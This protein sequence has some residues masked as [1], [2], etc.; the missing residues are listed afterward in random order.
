MRPKYLAFYQRQFPIIFPLKMFICRSFTF[1]L[2]F[3]VN[4][5]IYKF[6]EEWCK[7]ELFLTY[8]LHISRHPAIITINIFIATRTPHAHTQTHTNIIG[9]TGN[10]YESFNCCVNVYVRCHLKPW[11]QWNRKNKQTK[12]TN[13]GT[14]LFH[15]SELGRWQSSSSYILTSN[16]KWYACTRLPPSRFPVL[17]GV[18]SIYDQ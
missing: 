15:V 3:L 8:L 11:K 18:N 14:F 9:I 4:A 17:N 5:Y 12:L 10:L 7:F 16:G 2:L 1:C 13:F 6:E